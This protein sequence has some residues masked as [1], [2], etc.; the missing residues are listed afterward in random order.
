MIK[1]IS[2]IAIIVVLIALTLPWAQART[3]SYYSG[4]AINYNGT[5]VICTTDTGNLELFKLTGKNLSNFARFKS[6]NPVFNRQDN[7]YSCALNQ[8]G[9]NLFIYASTGALLNK[10]D[11]SGLNDSVDL[12]DSAKD[13]SWD[14][15]GG[16]GKLNSDR[17]Y[18]VGSNG[19]KIWNTDLQVIDSYKVVNKSNPY[20][21]RFSADNLT[22]YNAIGDDLQVYDNP[23]RQLDYTINLTRTNNRGNRQVYGVNNKLYVAE[24]NG[25]KMYNDAG[26]IV[27]SYDTK[28]QYGYDVAPSFDNQSIYVSVGNGL[29]KLA[30]SDLHLIKTVSTRF[31]SNSWA[32]GLK[33]V[34]GW[35]GERIVVFNNSNIA[36]YDNNLNRIAFTTATTEDTR[37]QVSEALSLSLSQLVAP[38]TAAVTIK[39]T[40]FAAKEPLTITLLNSTWE[41]TADDNG[42]FSQ[43]L[44]VPAVSQTLTVGTVVAPLRTEIAVKGQTSGRHYN[45]GFSIQQ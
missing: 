13:N 41:A 20:N 24:D 7:F 19:V 12:V 37:P 42:R 32:M 11:I 34:D 44:I 4:D 43:E 27:T 3:R 1:K 33:V 23:N 21:V 29:R 15:F 17:L 45:I 38:A 14:W 8:E 40:G 16:L 6:Y 36:V 10:Y 35:S 28:S 25:V 30:L 5:L 18:T 31:A 39:G 9:E 26:E 2:L 22:M